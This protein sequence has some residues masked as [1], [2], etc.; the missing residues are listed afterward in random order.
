M[1]HR[2]LFICCLLAAGVCLISSPAASRPV[3]ELATLEWPP[4]SGS[5]L[6]R[7]GYASEVV[8]QAFAASG[9]DTRLHFFPWERA[10]RSMKHHGYAGYTPEYYSETRRDCL[11]SAPF[12]AGPLF[13]FQ[14][15]GRNLHY[16]SLDDL[17]GLRIGTVSGYVN[18]DAFDSAEF[19]LKDPAVDDV[20][21][22]RKLLA[23][24]VD[25]IV[26]DALTLRFLLTRELGLPAGT[27]EPLEPP[28][29]NK[30][31]HVCFNPQHPAA[32]DYISAFNRGLEQMRHNGTLKAL[33]S[34]LYDAYMPGM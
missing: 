19:L 23:G 14:L 26:G 13:L 20:S 9:M 16:T 22:L 29:D 33:H 15:R 24:R 12:P 34:R 17:R 6:D 21:N 8:R 28:L 27:I 30:S 25:V 2:L 4:Y 31:L 32:G 1:L 10:I 7:Q 5:Y 18:T 11:F 3:A